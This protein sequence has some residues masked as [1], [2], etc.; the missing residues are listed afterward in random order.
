MTRL[1]DGKEVRMVPIDRIMV[2]NTRDRDPL[3]FAEI[4]ESIKSVGIKKPITVTVAFAQDGAESFHL[5]CGEGRLK[6]LAHL[7]ETQ[8]PVLVV[9]ASEEEAY[10]MG[11]VE[12]LARRRYRPLEL[13]TGIRLLHSKGYGVP[14]ISK[15]TGLSA[16]Y[17]KDLILLITHGEERM[18]SSVESGLLPIRAA[19]EIALAGDDD[20]SLQMTMHQ[21]YESGVLRGRQLLE[22]RKLLKQ[23]ATHGKTFTRQGSHTRPPVTTTSLVRTYQQEVERQ[24]MVVRKGTLVQDRLIIVISALRKIFSDENFVTLLRAEGLDTLPKYLAEKITGGQVGA[25]R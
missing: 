19:I 13:L 15:K 6:A 8:I 20:A 11:L 7:G 16:E 21:A 1:V 2:L 5:V 10:I 22:V 3:V 12:N 14:E 9:E 18:M 24:K 4:V 23:R 17:V 25:R